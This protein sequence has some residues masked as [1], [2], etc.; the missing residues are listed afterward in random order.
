MLINKEKF[1]KDIFEKYFKGNY[2]QCALAIGIET[3]QLHRFLNSDSQA[4]AK[5]IG[6]LYAYCQNN[7]LK[8]DEFIIL[9]RS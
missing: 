8:F 1:R 7:N 5:F 3:P 4:G 9:T 2:R 6:G